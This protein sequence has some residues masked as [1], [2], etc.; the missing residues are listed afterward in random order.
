MLLNSLKTYKI[1]GKIVTKHDIGRLI[2]FFPKSSHTNINH[3]KTQIGQILNV[4][5]YGVKAIFGNNIMY[6]NTE[7]CKY[8]NLEQ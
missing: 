6:V 3:P 7:K 5:I 2:Y 4:N 1:D 8:V